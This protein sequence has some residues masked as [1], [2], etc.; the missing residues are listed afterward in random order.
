[1]ASNLTEKLNSLMYE[2]NKT[3]TIASQSFMNQTPEGEMDV[4]K[5]S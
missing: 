5:Q 3:D 2:I 4:E 1:M